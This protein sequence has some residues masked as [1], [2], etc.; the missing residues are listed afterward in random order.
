MKRAGLML[1]VVAGLCLAAGCESDGP[2]PQDYGPPSGA[3]DNVNRT[4][5]DIRTRQ[6]NV[7][8]AMQSSTTQPSQMR[9]GVGGVNSGR[10]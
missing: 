6:D 2:R 5:S 3:V 4:P 7:P 10:P 1:A 8:P 9:S